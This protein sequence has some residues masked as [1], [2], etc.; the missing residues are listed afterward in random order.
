MNGHIYPAYF[1]TDVPVALCEIL[2][3]VDYERNSAEDIESGRN[4]VILLA[5]DMTQ[6]TQDFQVVS[7]NTNI[8]PSVVEAAN[9]VNWS[10]CPKDELE[11]ILTTLD[12]LV[13]NFL[14]VV[15]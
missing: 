3:N 14:K 1:A 10:L 8:H 2:E 13:R 5:S 12:G 11:R 6:K 7:R 15:E 4:M 9:L